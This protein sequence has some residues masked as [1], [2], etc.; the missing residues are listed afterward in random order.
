MR[1][2]FQLCLLLISD[3]GEVFG[4][5]KGSR[6]ASR[7]LTR[8]DSNIGPTAQNDLAPKPF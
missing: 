2:S 3:E 1:S 4:F 7:L 6:L 5:I 8:I